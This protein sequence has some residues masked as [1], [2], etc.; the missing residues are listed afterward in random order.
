LLR[1]V[2]V[3]GVVTPDAPRRQP[4]RGAYLHPRAECLALAERKRVFARALRLS[5]PAELSPLRA[6]V[7]QTGQPVAK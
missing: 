7:E 5:G 4:G 1:V 2:A 3:S 6:Y